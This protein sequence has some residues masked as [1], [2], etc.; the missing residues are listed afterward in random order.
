MN[1]LQKIAIGLAL[2]AAGPAIW[3]VGWIFFFPSFQLTNG[4][5]YGEWT[6]AT[7]QNYLTLGI[8]G[9][10]IIGFLLIAWKGDAQTIPCKSETGLAPLHSSSQSPT[11]TGFSSPSSLGGPVVSSP[12]LSEL[13]SKVED[14]GKRMEGIEQSQAKLKPFLKLAPEEK[15]K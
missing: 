9:I 8:S 10:Y 15:Q 13:L 3:S 1:S 7:F 4:Q 5:Y 12:Q 14:I 2:I 11:E 6:P